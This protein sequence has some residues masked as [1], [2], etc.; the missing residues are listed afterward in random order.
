MSSEPYAA[1][2][3]QSSV[4]VVCRPESAD[5]DQSENV[6]ALVRWID[7]LCEGNRFAPRLIVFPVLTLVG[8]SRRDWFTTDMPLDL[9]GD[10]LEPLLLPLVEACSRHGCYVVT[11]TVEKH[12]KLP[13]HLF[14]SG[15]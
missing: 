15:F 14:H 8:A 11:S 4:E 13:G 6:A 10:R 2:V 1:A 7:F 12:A 5:R 3:V 9:T